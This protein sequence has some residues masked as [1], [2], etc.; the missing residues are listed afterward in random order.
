VVL[1]QPEARARAARLPPE[2]AWAEILGRYPT[3]AAQFGNACP[4]RPIGFIP[5]LQ[6]RLERAA[7]EGWALLPHAFFFASPMFSTGI[8]WSLLAVER[9]ALVLERARDMSEMDLSLERYGDLLHR[10]ADHLSRLVEGGYEAAARDFDLFVPWTDLYFAAASFGEIRQRLFDSREGG[11]AW[12]WEGFLGSSD[13]VILEALRETLA[14]LRNGPDPQ[15]FAD[16]VRQ[17]IARRNLAGLADPARNRLYPVALEP[18]VRN[19]NLLGLSEE[20]L[21]ERM[22][23]LRGHF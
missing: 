14:D 7:G 4:V 9:L 23:R 5:R 11:E 8:A 2:D 3:L 17:R 20:E 1:A 16:R 21:R 10:E 12:A 13:S 22:P 19:C 6:H 18:L 15:A